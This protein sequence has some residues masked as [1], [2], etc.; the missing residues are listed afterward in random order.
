[1][2]GIVLD[3]DN[4]HTILLDLL[5][6]IQAPDIMASKTLTGIAMAAMFWSHLDPQITD[7]L[8]PLWITKAYCLH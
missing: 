6:K 2:Q 1:M 3:N 5:G 4:A 7:S 8:G